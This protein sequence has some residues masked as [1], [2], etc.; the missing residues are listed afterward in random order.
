L[1]GGKEPNYDAANVDSACQSLSKAGLR[2]RIMI[3]ASHSNSHK[4]YRNQPLVVENIAG[5]IE[6]GDARIFGIM[7][8]SNLIDGRQDLVAGQPLVYGQSITDGCIGW[9]ASVK[10]LERL[11]EAVK[12][13]RKITA[14]PVA[15]VHSE[16]A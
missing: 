13:R 16:S 12:N 4:D 10:V 9:D 15:A 14:Q 2:E 3:D 1:R 5:Q 6:G 11:S 8:E 7:V